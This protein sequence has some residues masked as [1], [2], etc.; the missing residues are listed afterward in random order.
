MTYKELLAVS[1][2]LVKENKKEEEAVKF[3]LL[4]MSELSSSQFYHDFDSETP[5][6]FDTKFLEYV[7]EYIHN[8]I[9]VQHLLGYSYFYGRKFF[10]NKDAFIPRNETEE[11]VENILIT[12]DE[13]FMD[14]KVDVLDLGTGSGAISI[15]LALEELNMNV[16]ATD[17]SEEALVV[18]NKNASNLL[19]SVKF[20]KSDWFKNV[21][22][23]F[24]IIVSNPP[25]IPISEELDNIVLK[26][27]SL[28]LFGGVDGTTYYEIILKDAWKHLKDYGLI[29]FEHGYNQASK[30]KE[31]AKKYL[32][33]PCIKVIKDM[34]GKDRMT[35][36]GLGGVLKWKKA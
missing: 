36:I 7:N 4:E 5:K 9:P 19:A 10:I 11:L 23:K 27:P 34:Y 24:D 1:T 3:L 14:K 30:I 17:L 20:L 32:D 29:A 26:D 6:G 18:A 12:Y 13:Y 16:S 8:D 2:K 21:D 15:S 28:A 25:Y 31:Y 33:N 35:L 22:G